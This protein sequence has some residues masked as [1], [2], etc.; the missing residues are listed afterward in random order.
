MP[1]ITPRLLHLG[2]AV[3]AAATLLGACTRPAAL[4]S[5]Y[6]G[7][8]PQQRAAGETARLE[9]EIL[10]QAG[11]RFAPDSLV[12]SQYRQ[13]AEDAFTKAG[14]SLA[15]KAPLEVRITLAGRTPNG[16][17]TSEAAHGRNLAVGLLTLGIAC[18]EWTHTVDA[19][20]TV[21]LLET[22]TVAA[23][24]EI[25]LKGTAESCHSTGNPNWLAN[26]QQAAIDTY[27]QAAQAH[28]AAVL[29][30]VAATTLAPP[31]A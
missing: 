2:L 14:W 3:L 23:S 12:Q 15:P 11:Q 7:P 1:S 21:T 24:K 29:E 28:L 30:F 25:D 17:V 9:I 16:V 20:G 4:Q 22:G 26:Q 27:Q 13:L 19:A 31:P 18:N 5:S 10:D 8:L 6:E